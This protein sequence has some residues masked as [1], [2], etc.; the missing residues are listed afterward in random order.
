VSVQFYRSLPTIPAQPVVPCG[1]PD[2][3]ATP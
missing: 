1:L 3:P 2:G